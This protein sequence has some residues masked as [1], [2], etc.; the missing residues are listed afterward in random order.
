MDDHLAALDKVLERCAK[1]KLFIKTE[2]CIFCQPEI[3]CLGD[4]IG[5]NGVRMDPKKCDSIRDWPLPK[6]K[7]EMRAFIGTCVYVMLFC[8]GFAEQVALLTELTRKK[9]PQDAITLSPQH[10]EAFSTLKQKLPSPPVLSH[11]DFT[12]PFHV[13]VDA[14][15]FAVV[16][17]LFQLD[18]KGAEPVIADGGRKLAKPELVYPTCEKELLAA[19]HTM[20]IW[21]IYLLNR[22]FFLNTDHHTIESILQQQSYSQR[23]ARWL[24]ELALF[25]PLFKWVPGSTNVV[26]DA[27]SR[28]AD[29]NDG[30]ARAISLST[31]NNSMAVSGATSDSEELLLYQSPQAIDIES[32][33][34]QG[35]AADK[36]FGPIVR[37]LLAA[38]NPASRRCRRFTLENEL[39]YFQLRPTSARRLCI[40][41]S[42][43]LRKVSFSKNMMFHPVATLVKPKRCM[44]WKF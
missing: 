8:E 27:I 32:E 15:D 36:Y 17:Y 29:W 14:S 11:P 13:N 1:E 21:K 19:L 34:R 6:T 38:S 2:K 30:T 42:P 24:Y 4:Y 37:D 16:G 7:R 10:L 3:P 44:S 39:L 43:G 33:C 18:E 26:A 40:P 5:R 28:R 12:K 9:R 31:L 23:L 20:R 35:Y 41:D 22:P 25:Q